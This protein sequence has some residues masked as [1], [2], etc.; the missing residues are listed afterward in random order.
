M[1]DWYKAKE[2]AV[3]CEKRCDRLF[4]FLDDRDIPRATKEIAEIR[5]RLTEIDI[6][7][8]ADKE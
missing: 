6:E 1:I 2:L 8:G 4:L 5:N 7:I 3:A